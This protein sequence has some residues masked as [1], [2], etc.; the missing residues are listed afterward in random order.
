MYTHRFSDFDHLV[1]MLLTELPSIPAE[2]LVGIVRHY[3]RS[4]TPASGH[5]DLLLVAVARPE[6]DDAQLDAVLAARA[7]VPLQVRGARLAG[8]GARPDADPRA[9]LRPE[10]SL[11]AR[12]CAAELTRSPQLLAELVVKAPPKLVVAAL[13]NPWRSDDVD[14]A[15]IDMLEKPHGYLHYNV[16]ARLRRTPRVEERVR[17]SDLH[18]LRCRAWDWCDTPQERVEL[19]T[20]EISAAVAAGDADRLID[21]VLSA[22]EAPQL[23]TSLLRDLELMLDARLSA[24]ADDDSFYATWRRTDVQKTLDQVRRILSTQADDPHPPVSVLFDRITHAHYDEPER[25]A[26]QRLLA[27]AAALL[28]H[29]PDFWTC[30]A[31]SFDADASIPEIVSLALLLASRPKR[32]LPAKKPYRPKGVAVITG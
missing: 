25:Q 23:P 12:L 10:R 13:G 11:K 2:D 27:E 29:G 4:Q 1:F 31:G 16:E 21:T 15:A 14:L 18:S 22:D 9:L 32:R 28:G 20:R 30:L 24:L 8:L 5:V 3:L 17:A 19:A 7:D 6:F 26:E